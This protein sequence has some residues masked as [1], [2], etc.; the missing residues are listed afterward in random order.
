MKA[1]DFDDVRPL[2]Q[3]Q[4]AEL[5]GRSVGYVRLCR[6]ASAPKGQVFPMRGWKTDGKRYLLPAWR[7]REWVESLPDA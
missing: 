4:V 5:I 6:Q 7:L 1:D 3:K 2:T